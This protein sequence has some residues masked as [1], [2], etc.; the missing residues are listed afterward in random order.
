MYAVSS[1]RKKPMSQNECT[2]SQPIRVPAVVTY[3]MSAAYDERNVPYVYTSGMLGA[4]GFEIIMLHNRLDFDQLQIAVVEAIEL[5]RDGK[6][7][8]GDVYTTEPFYQ[9]VEEEAPTTRFKLIQHETQWLVHGFVQRYISD[10][11]FG[12]IKRL[13]QVQMADIDNRLPDEEGYDSRVIQDLQY[14]LIESKEKS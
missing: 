11:A 8:I 2:N 14:S 13:V 6:I 4:F 3:P 5:L 12:L 1:E 7:K 9:S 10:D